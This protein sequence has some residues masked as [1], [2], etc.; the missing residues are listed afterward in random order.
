MLY[1]EQKDF[2]FIHIPKAA[3]TSVVKYLKAV[4]PDLECIGKH[5]NDISDLSQMRIE[6]H[7]PCGLLN[8]NRTTL[9]KLNLSKTTFLA[10]LRN[11]LDIWISHYHWGV[12]KIKIYKETPLSGVWNAAYRFA[13]SKK[14]AYSGV[15]EF[16]DEG[17]NNNV[18][19]NNYY[20]DHLGRSLFVRLTQQGVF[21]DKLF[22]VDFNK[23]TELLPLFVS[24]VLGVTDAGLEIGYKNKVAYDKSQLNCPEHILER[25]AA[26]FAGAFDQFLFDPRKS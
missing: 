6:Q 3:G 19:R 1:S 12:R 21:P 20:N 13:G 11:P 25:D 15:S 2:A 17:V 5:H 10:I 7:C 24:Q 9:P 14:T 18:K 26:Y 8:P 4:L 16:L 22:L 23:L